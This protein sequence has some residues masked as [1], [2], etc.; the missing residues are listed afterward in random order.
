MKN[1]SNSVRLLQ[2]KNTD[3]WLNWAISSYTGLF[4][5]GTPPYSHAEIWWPGKDDEG[6]VDWY[7]GECFTSTMRGD[8]NGTVIRPVYEVLDHPENWDY[9]QF[10]NI[11]PIKYQ[12]AIGLARIAA[13]Q[14]QGYDK[15]AL[16]SFFFP[17]RFGSRK[18]DICSETSERFLYHCGILPKATMP[19]PR[20]LARK[21]INSGYSFK[22]LEEN[23]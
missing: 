14:N 1:S 19:S 2:Y 23:I 10:D 20:R 3:R 6:L 17:V 11:N 4:N 21:I 9:C 18:A 5:P 16:L 8:L 22:S 13:K 12:A 15:P 7:A